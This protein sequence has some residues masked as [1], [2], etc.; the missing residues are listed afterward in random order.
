MKSEKEEFEIQ[1]HLDEELERAYK[2]LGEENYNYKLEEKE[3]ILLTYC[4]IVIIE[5]GVLK[6]R[7]LCWKLIK[8]LNNTY[9]PHRSGLEE[10]YFTFYGF[11]FVLVV[12]IYTFYAGFHYLDFFVILL[13][14]LSFMISVLIFKK[15]NPALANIIGNVTY[16][17]ESVKFRNGDHQK[18]L[19]FYY[20]VMTFYAI[21]AF[22]TS[23]AVLIIYLLG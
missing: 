19:Y 5:T 9:F 15:I 11:L 12:G 10:F 16:A 2:E 8:R 7:A 17:K 3:L 6:L 14:T 1:L 18:N 4:L 13:I 22:S 21:C 20:F 23:I